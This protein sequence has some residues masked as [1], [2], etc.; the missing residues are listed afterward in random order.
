MD[1]VHA[2]RWS[3]LGR[4]IL[5]GE[6]EVTAAHCPDCGAQTLTCREVGRRTD[7]TGYAEVRCRDCGHGIYVV[8]AFGQDGYPAP[9]FIGDE[10]RS[11]RGPE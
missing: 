4:E 10:G 5:R 7:R 8:R 3:V 2:N 11:D 9:P 1:A 6:V